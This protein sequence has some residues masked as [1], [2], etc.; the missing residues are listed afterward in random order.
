MEKTLGLYKLINGSAVKFPSADNWAK[1]GDYKYSATRM[2]NAP[3]ITATLI[4]PTCLD[5]LWGDDVF[6]EFRGE[7]YFINGVPSSSRANSKTGYTHNV[8][9]ISERSIL[10]R[11][12]FLDIIQVQNPPGAPENSLISDRSDFSFS[13]NLE[14]LASRLN[15]SLNSSGIGFDNDGYSVVVDPDVDLEDKLFSVSNQTI[16]DV[17]NSANETFNIPYYFVGKTIHFGYYQDELKTAVEYGAEGSLLS[18]NKNSSNNDIITKITGFGSDKNIPYY[19]PNPTPKGFVSLSYTSDYWDTN[20]NYPRIENFYKFWNFLEFGERLSYDSRLH[21]SYVPLMYRKDYSVPSS[22]GDFNKWYSPD[23]IDILTDSLWTFEIPI[24]N[25]ENTVF[26]L[27]ITVYDVTDGDKVF[28]DYTIER[29]T[30]LSNDVEHGGHFTI[31]SNREIIYNADLS[32][33]D[34]TYNVYLTLKFNSSNKYR[35]VVSKSISP[36]W[37]SN[38]KSGTYQPNDF[39]LAFDFD[40]WFDD[41]ISMRLEYRIN[42]QSR[43]MPSTYRASNGRDRWIYASGNEYE[44]KY[45]QSHPMEYIYTDDEIYPTI[46]NVKNASGQRIDIFSEIAFDET[47][48]NEVYPEGH[49]YAG[50]YKHPYFF[51][52]LR[53]LDG[54]DG[55]NLFQHTIE[56]Q[57]MTISF[58]SGHVA[59]CEFKIAVDENSMKNT[60]QVDGEGN[61]KRDSA[62]DVLCNRGEQ[63]RLEFVERQQ[64]TSKYEVWIALEKEDSTM[65]VMM[66]DSMSNIIPTASDTFVILGIH[67]PEAYFTAA[68]KKLDDALINHMIEN[69]SHKFTYSAELSS[70]FLKENPEIYETL[71]ENSRVPLL[72]NGKMISWLM[73]ES[74]NYSIKKGQ[75][76]PDISITL[77]DNIKVATSKSTATSKAISNANTTASKSQSMATSAKNQASSTAAKTQSIERRVETL[78]QNSNNITV[79]KLKTQVSTNSS[80]I[81]ELDKRVTAI[82]KNGGGGGGTSSSITITSSKPKY[83]SVTE[84]P[85]GTFTILPK[86]LTFNEYG[87]SPDE[88]LNFGLAMT[89]DVANQI[90]LVKDWVG[91]E[92]EAYLPVPSSTPSNDAILVYDAG[93]GTIKDSL[94]KISTTTQD[95]YNEGQSK[96]PTCGQVG[97][98]ITYVIENSHIGDLED[99]VANGKKSIKTASLRIVNGIIEDDAIVYAL[100]TAP[101]QSLEE[102]D[103]VIATNRY[104]D[105]IVGDINTLLETI[106]VG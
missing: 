73:V 84:S 40:P 78:E 67:L 34:V 29:A 13:G 10:S 30:F 21:K 69:N 79:D 50:K 87:T 20:R 82:E 104:V 57:P 27:E 25:V 17:L 93:N 59:S 66:P 89:E 1:L 74:Y 16:I 71:N 11:V 6:V 39:G 4:W 94:Y 46:T 83:I 53:K 55:F 18:V 32:S 92:L 12:Y 44:N 75:Y 62:G 63:Q 86:V 51:A 26:E 52:K 98:F 24:E 103:D 5:E 9:F 33:E 97:E 35:I 45:T 61:L 64:D 68:E 101:E 31:V 48:N 8:E 41:T 95:L 3:S 49:K 14:E 43:L 28:T 80:D 72:Y 105:S 77:N 102:A 58:T 100:P 81:Y 2:G 90:G 22:D 36:A 42:T 37:V 65:G 7:K 47:D 96:I 60:V 56:G 38:I 23:G 85:S 70:I 15:I 91:Q 54:D 88:S 99:R 106:I 19:Y 76:L